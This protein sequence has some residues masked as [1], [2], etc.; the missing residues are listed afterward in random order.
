MWRSYHQRQKMSYEPHYCHEQLFN[1]LFTAARDAVRT[2]L[3]PMGMEETPDLVQVGLQLI[4]GLA[5]FLFSVG[6]LSDDLRSAVGERVSRGLVRAGRYT[7][8]SVAVG[9]AASAVLDSSSAV[10]I[11]AIVLVHA[12]T[13]P[14]RNALGTVLGA[15]LGTTF[16]SQI[17]AFDILAWSPLLLSLGFVLTRLR[18]T[19]GTG[20]DIAFHLGLLF[21]G[22]WTMEQAV[23]P[24]HGHPAFLAALA[25]TEAPLTGVGWGAAITAIL[26]SSSA[27]VG[28]VIVLAKHHLISSPGGIAVM[29]G[30]ELGTCA[31]T[32]LATVGTGR[33]AL[34]TSIFHIAFNLVSIAGGLLFFSPF[35]QL[36]TSLATFL[37]VPDMASHHIALAHVVFNL[38][39]VL[40]FLGAI[41]ASERLLN[42]LLP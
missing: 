37:H 2:Y 39:G 8:G 34:K 22:L 15:N 5:L 29:M 13:L 33:A 16:G 10:I 42:R 26:Q 38:C 11:L 17:I 19:R 30:A 27:T 1:D 40:L 23:L 35:V 36:T 18:R 32:L 3:P 25:R 12:G 14:L 20:A 21:F 24:L 4:A 28:M 9:C 41:P 31:D 7:I 6:R